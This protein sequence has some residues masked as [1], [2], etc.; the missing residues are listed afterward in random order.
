MC[1]TAP[2]F[3]IKIHV[4][5]LTNCFYHGVEKATPKANTVLN[6]I[7]LM[8]RTAGGSV[9]LWKD[10]QRVAT[11]GSGACLEWVCVLSGFSKT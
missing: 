10:S 3:F 2:S 1:A 8:T 9:L 4:R 7:L 11:Y 5:M 6:A